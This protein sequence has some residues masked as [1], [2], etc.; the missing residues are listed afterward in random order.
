MV[1]PICMFLAAT[2]A[3]LLHHHITMFPTALLL[4]LCCVYSG[5]VEPLFNG[6]VEPLFNGESDI[7]ILAL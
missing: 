5:V 3:I 4:G 7:C 2:R 1:Q 6:V